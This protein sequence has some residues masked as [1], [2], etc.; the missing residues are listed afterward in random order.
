MAASI[1]YSFCFY[2]TSAAAVA[3]YPHMKQLGGKVFTPFT[4]TG[5]RGPLSEIHKRRIS[6]KLVRTYPQ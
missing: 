1:P 3:K 4:V 5:F 6:K 2:L